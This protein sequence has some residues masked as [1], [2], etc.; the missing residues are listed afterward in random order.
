MTEALAHMDEDK[1]LDAALE[2]ATPRLAESLQREE[3]QRRQ[4]RLL[5]MGGL[6]MSLLAGSIVAFVLL[7]QPDAGVENPGAPEN[8]IEAVSCADALG[9]EGW[10]LWNAREYPAAADKFTAAIKL[11]PGAADLWNGLGWSLF[12]IPQQRDKSAEAFAEALKHNEKHPAALNGMGQLAFVKRDYD[13]AK[14]W[15]EKAKDSAPA[16]RFTLVSVYLLTGEFDKAKDLSAALLAMLPEQTD[17]DMLRA[18]RE[19]MTTLHAAAESGVLSDDVRQLIEPPLPK[20]GD[21]AKAEQLSQQGWQLWGQR[22]MRAAELAFRE[23]IELDDTNANAFNGLGWALIGQGKAGDAQAP[24]E[25]AI[26]LEPEHGGAIN[27]LGMS[28]KG[29]GKIDEAVAIWEDLYRK[30]PGPHAG[31]VNLARTYCERKQYDK[32]I[33]ILEM[34]V[35]A[36]PE[37]AECREMLEQ[38]RAGLL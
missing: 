23:S 1:A 21:P 28:L 16:A 19:H 5:I 32:V 13:A 4:F 14:N 2:E 36:M 35:Q 10:Q 9:R 6:V 26:A 38:A 20:K 31:A 27:G 30:S 11:D 37:H 18:Q 29:Q 7:S 22:K 25:K 15:L 3:R 33:P 12:H 8:Q 34:L 17:N 24:L